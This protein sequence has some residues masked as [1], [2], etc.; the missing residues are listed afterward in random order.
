MKHIFYIISVQLFHFFIFFFFF[1]L[2]FTYI[3]N[4]FSV[5]V[6]DKAFQI[7]LI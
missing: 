5:K 6:F 3:F 4:D 7:S 1:L 2:P